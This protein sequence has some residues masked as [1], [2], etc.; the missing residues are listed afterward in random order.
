MKHHMNSRLRKN[1]SNRGKQRRLQSGKKSSTHLHILAC[2]QSSNQGLVRSG[3]VRVCMH[4]LWELA[5]AITMQSPEGQED[6]TGT[7]RVGI[8]VEATIRTV[9][10]D[11]VVAMVVAHI[12]NKDE[13]LLLT[14]VV[15]LVVVAVVAMELVDQISHKV[16]LA[17]MVHLV[18]AEGRTI[19]KV[20]LA[21]SNSMVTGSNRGSNVTSLKCCFSW[22]MYLQCLYYVSSFC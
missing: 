18:Q 8:K 20:V 21:I 15:V 2:L 16:A 12:H 17:R 1:V 22:T 4:H 14:L 13:G 7:H 5:Q 9:A 11:R 10:E 19:A 6:L 3:L